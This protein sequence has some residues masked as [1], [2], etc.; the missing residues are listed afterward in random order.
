MTVLLKELQAKEQRQ[1]TRKNT[2]KGNQPTVPNGWALFKRKKIMEMNGS[3]A[4]ESTTNL[5]WQCL[6]TGEV[7]STRETEKLQSRRSQEG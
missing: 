6:P 7:S 3:A 4:R 2:K 5:S 1:E